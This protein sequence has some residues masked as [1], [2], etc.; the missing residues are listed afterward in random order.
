MRPVCQKLLLASLMV[1]LFGSDGRPQDFVEGDV[2]GPTNFNGLSSVGA[3]WIGFSHDIGEGVGY[4]DGYSS[5]E[6]FVPLPLSLDNALFF[7]DLR[8]IV[9][10]NGELGGNVGF[11]Y[12]VYDE[13]SN[14]VFGLLLDYRLCCGRSKPE[15][16]PR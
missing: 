13:D 14:R 3:P 8:F 12:R 10:N 4:R 1:L 9:D 2:L 16:A 6:G 5:F 11:G 15:S 7:A